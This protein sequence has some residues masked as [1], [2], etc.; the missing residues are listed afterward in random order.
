MIAISEATAV[1]RQR[2]EANCTCCYPISECDPMVRLSTPV[3]TR[4]SSPSKA[5]QTLRQS[6]GWQ[7]LTCVYASFN[8]PVHSYGY[9]SAGVTGDFRAQEMPCVVKAS[10]RNCQR[11][12]AR[13]TVLDCGGRHCFGGGTGMP[14]DSA[15]K[16]L[17]II[18][19]DYTRANRQ[20]NIRSP[21]STSYCT[22]GTFRC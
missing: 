10:V 3:T 4:Y 13:I 11:L 16:T 9:P 21:H 14:A 19:L 22:R 17:P 5:Q 12:S 7:R 2:R 15:I 1:L 8:I 20:G 18:L 6:D